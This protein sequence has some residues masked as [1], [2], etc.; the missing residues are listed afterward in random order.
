M[1]KISI[2]T[3]DA[4]ELQ[5]MFSESAKEAARIVLEQYQGN[6]EKETDDGLITKSQAAELLKVSKSTIDGHARAG[7]LTRHKIG[8]AVRF[9]KTEVMGLAKTY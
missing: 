9:D 3:I 1:T 6:G 5:R 7:R 2:V 8:R 4:D